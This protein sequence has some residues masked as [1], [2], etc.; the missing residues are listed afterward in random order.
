MDLPSWLY[1][2]NG[3]GWHTGSHVIHAYSP[4]E[5]TIAGLSIEQK[6]ESF[7]YDGDMLL[8]SNFQLKKLSSF[9]LLL[10]VYQLKKQYRKSLE[11]AN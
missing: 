10:V 8:G 1:V 11:L 6:N 2:C 7:I 5:Q 3:H 9:R 4:G